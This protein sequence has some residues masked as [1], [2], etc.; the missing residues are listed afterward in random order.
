M[1]KKID[2]FNQVQSIKNIF[3]EIK[4]NITLKTQEEQEDF[5]N[6]MRNC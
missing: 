3:D 6:Y 1:K 5:L 2:L 4:S